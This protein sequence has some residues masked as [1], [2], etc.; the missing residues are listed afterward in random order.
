[1]RHNVHGPTNALS[2]CVPS[3]RHRPLTFPRSAQV[4][5]ATQ[6]YLKHRSGGA[7]YWTAAVRTLSAENA[8]IRG[9]RPD[10]SKQYFV[11][12]TAIGKFSARACCAIEERAASSLT[13]GLRAPKNLV[14]TRK[15]QT[16][17]KQAAA[18]GPAARLASLGCLFGRHPSPR[19]VLRLAADR[20]A[21]PV[22]L[23]ITLARQ[24][25]SR[26][27]RR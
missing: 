8:I 15:L 25:D 16:R 10:T 19:R 6:P 27:A 12:F 9:G 26:E 20:C 3:Q 2:R 14:H 7:A 11:A 5:P 22:R 23:E 18:P 17:G 1:M 24:Q 13:R 4:Q 21:A